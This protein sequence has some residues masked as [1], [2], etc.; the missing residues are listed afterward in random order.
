M[1]KKK[2]SLWKKNKNLLNNLQ[3][4]SSQFSEHLIDVKNKK[5]SYKNC[6]DIY[7]HIRPNS[8]DLNSSNINQKG[9]DFI[10]FFIDNLKNYEQDTIDITKPFKRLMIT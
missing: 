5:M 1:F 6:I 8:Y 7:G 4:I 9:R 10:N 3:T 2:L